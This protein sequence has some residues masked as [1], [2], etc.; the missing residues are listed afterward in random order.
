MER[1]TRVSNGER[2]FLIKWILTLSFF[3]PPQS[4]G[5][6][7]FW[8][9]KPQVYKKVVEERRVIVSVTD[10]SLDDIRLMK[11]KGGGQIHAPKDF[12]FN[13]MKDFK[14][15]FKNS[16]YIKKIEVDEKNKSLFIRA[17]AY[18]FS[19]S[20]KVDWSVL[21]DEPEESVLSFHV[22]EGIMKGF[23]WKMILEPA[24]SNRSDV[25]VDGVYKYEKFPLP[26]F[27]LQFGL[28]LIFQNMAIDL[29]N[30]V[31][32]SFSESAKKKGA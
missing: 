13:K 18:G 20:M 19:N 1:Q 3:C 14:S 16:R 27:F 10:H 28:E 30:Q 22:R 6:M 26:G 15:V 11:L 2:A 31:E 23:E 25:G 32:E 17:V 21:K 9:A 7:P 5:E 8:K 29:R 4:W 12:S 24:K